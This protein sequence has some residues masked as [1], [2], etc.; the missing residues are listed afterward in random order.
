[1]ARENGTTVAAR[2]LT[3][4][5]S[6]ILDQRGRGDDHGGPEGDRTLRAFSEPQIDAGDYRGVAPW[7]RHDPEGHL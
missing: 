1:L 2:L 5:V 7:P 6:D 4:C 3:R